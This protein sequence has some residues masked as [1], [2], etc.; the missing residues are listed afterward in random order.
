[1]EN[2]GGQ[3]KYDLEER[4]FRFAE[5]SRDFVKMIPRT[6]SNIEYGKQ[7]IRSSSSVPANHIESCESLSKKDSLMRIKICRKEAKE[8]RLWVRLIETDTVESK[9]LADWLIDESLQLTRIFGAIVNKD[10]QN[11]V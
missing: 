5:K 6:I 1:M 7:L 4:T 8:S 9:E 2:A 11:N 3:K 10:C